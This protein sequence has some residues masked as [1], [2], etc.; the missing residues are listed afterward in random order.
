MIDYV[1]MRNV[2]D[3]NKHL[4][5]VLCKQDDYDFIHGLFIS[6]INHACN[7]HAKQKHP[8]CHSRVEKSFD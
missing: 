2:I 4:K 5:H 3:I 8:G 7:M 6:T 1:A